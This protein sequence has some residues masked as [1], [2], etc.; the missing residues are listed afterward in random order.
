MHVL[1]DFEFRECAEPQL[2]KVFPGY[3]DEMDAFTEP[4]SPELPGRIILFPCIGGIFEDRTGNFDSCLSAQV[5]INAASKLGDIGCYLIPWWNGPSNFCYI[6][7]DEFVECYAGKPGSNS[8]IGI[9]LSIYPY[10]SESVIYSSQGQWGLLMSHEYHAI[11]VGSEDFIEEIRLATPNIDNQ[12]YA[13]FDHWKDHRERNL[14]NGI[15]P[16][17]YKWLPILLHHV[18]GI[19][20]GNMLLQE[21]GLPW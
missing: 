7:L 8:L 21:S 15:D 16:G 5:L 19:E 1:S 6:P 11:L 12:V 9:K 18:Y 17:P 4:C 2:K 10:S 3:N 13:F 14:S 20:K